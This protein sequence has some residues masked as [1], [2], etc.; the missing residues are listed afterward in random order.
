MGSVAISISNGVDWTVYI[1]QAQ[2]RSSDL[3]LQ[4]CPSEAHGESGA[5]RCWLRHPYWRSAFEIWSVRVV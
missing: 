4:E 5:Y 3:C 2:L 1:H